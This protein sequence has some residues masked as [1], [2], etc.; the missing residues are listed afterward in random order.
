M[1][2]EDYRIQID[3]IDGQL[4]ALLNKRAHYAVEIGKLKK[5]V[6]IPVYDPARE[7]KI[8]GRLIAENPGPLDHRSILILFERIIDESRRIERQVSQQNEND[9]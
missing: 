6:N 2:I 3:E 4:L 8:L 7:K 1:K 9:L 5:K